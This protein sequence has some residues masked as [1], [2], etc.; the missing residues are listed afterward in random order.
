M[1]WDVA[2]ASGN[3]AVGEGE[4]VMGPGVC[5]GGENWRMKNWRMNVGLLEGPHVK[6]SCERM[7]KRIA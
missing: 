1:G 4:V 2:L 7:G 3:D 5:W 6:P